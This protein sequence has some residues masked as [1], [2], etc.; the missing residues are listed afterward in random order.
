MTS[1]PNP[2]FKIIVNG[3]SHAVEIIDNGT[4]SLDVIVDGQNF[5]VQIQPDAPPK[6][7]PGI[8]STPKAGKQDA[9]PPAPPDLSEPLS[10]DLTAPL[11]GVIAEIHVTVGDQVSSGQEMC[12]IEAMKMKNV[13]R[14]HRSGEIAA[15]DVAIGET[16]PYNKTLIRFK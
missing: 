2:K 5:K 10:G 7:D 16:V 11:P 4:A 9:N 12:V 1:N 3:Q 8:T 14:S 6:I 13:L 15:V